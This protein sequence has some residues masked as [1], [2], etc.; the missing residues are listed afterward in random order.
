M[1][2]LHLGFSEEL[3]RGSAG[4]TSRLDVHG[5]GEQRKLRCRQQEDRRRGELALCQQIPEAPLRWAGGRVA[6]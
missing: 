5:Q 1:F 4:Q 2:N 3:S 6:A